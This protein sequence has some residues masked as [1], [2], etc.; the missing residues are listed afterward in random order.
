MCL[1]C[2][3]VGSRA[4]F[5]KQPDGMGTPDGACGYKDY[6]R[7]VNDGAVCTVYNKLF[8]NGAGCG[9]C[10]NVICTNKAL[11]NSAGTKVV[12]TD[13]GGRPPGSD[14]ICSYLAF[15]KLARP[16]KESELIKKG[17][18]D[19]IYEKVPCNYPKNLIIKI[20]DQSSN[21][22]YLGFAV[23]N[24]GD[25]QTVEVYDMG[26]KAWIAMRRVYDGVFDLSNPPEGALKVRFTIEPTMEDRIQRLEA[27]VIEINSKIDNRFQTTQDS[28]NKLSAQFGS[29]R[30]ELMQLLSLNQPAPLV[31]GQSPG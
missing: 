21:P 12:T 9:S 28:V 3:L 25:V 23:L 26:R 19:V 1:I 8:N 7:T 31:M 22:W 20:T 10:H 2:K 29:L 30:G 14:F 24:Q 13:N 4:T 11:C 17:V 15:T 5:Y 16:G 27:I 18:I 6:G